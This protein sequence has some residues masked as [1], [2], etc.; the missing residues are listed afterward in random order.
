MAR[1]Y[2]RPGEERSGR[3]DTS[4]DARGHCGPEQG[5]RA[6]GLTYAHLRTVCDRRVNGITESGQTLPVLTVL[7]PRRPTAQTPMS[8]NAPVQPGDKP[9]GKNGGGTRLNESACPKFH[10]GQWPQAVHSLANR[11]LGHG[12]MGRRHSWIRARGLSIYYS[13]TDRDRTCLHEA[14]GSRDGISGHVTGTPVK[15]G[16]SRVESPRPQREP[17]ITSGENSPTTSSV[18]VQSKRNPAEL[19]SSSGES[20]SSLTITVKYKALL[21]STSGS[22][23]VQPRGWHSTKDLQVTP[24]SWSASRDYL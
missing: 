14:R 17:K 15:E 6:G 23:A 24:I 18:E 2:R 12:D 20:M 9:G 13:D 7:E 1:S 19:K 21:R 4:A 11:T 8:N 22:G 16:V 3:S 10:L 5:S